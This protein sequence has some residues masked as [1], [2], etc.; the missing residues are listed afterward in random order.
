LFKTHLAD[1]AA[2]VINSNLNFGMSG[3]DCDE[4]VSSRLVPSR[5]GYTSPMSNLAASVEAMPIL[6]ADSD[7]DAHWITPI[8]HSHAR[9]T[10][11]AATIATILS[12]K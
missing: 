12:S 3:Q 1:A 2:R 9:A 6:M 11:M 5:E 7:R 10:N 8:D 4:I